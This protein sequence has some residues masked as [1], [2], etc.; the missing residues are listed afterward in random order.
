MS[1]SRPS[2]RITSSNRPELKF[3]EL[4]LIEQKNRVTHLHR[5]LGLVGFDL[6]HVI[7]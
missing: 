6:S 1:G 5:S 3:I 2:V 4:M 7:L